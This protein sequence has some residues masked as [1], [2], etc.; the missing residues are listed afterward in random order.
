MVKLVNCPL[1]PIFAVAAG[2]HP[3]GKASVAVP[4]EKAKVGGT[5]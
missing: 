3:E 2:Q 4:D 5:E 1:L